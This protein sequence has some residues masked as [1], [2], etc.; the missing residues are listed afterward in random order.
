MRKPKELH[1]FYKST[2]WQV[3][4]EIKI[5]AANGKC[6][7]CGAL[8]KEVHHKIRLTVLNLTNPE[9]SLNQ[10]NLELLCNKCHNEEHKR[11]S[12]QQQFD[13]DGNLISR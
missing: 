10:E 9:I 2:Q 12:K 8:G 11:F 4:R 6:E 7:R 13:E 1:R 3:V 5:R